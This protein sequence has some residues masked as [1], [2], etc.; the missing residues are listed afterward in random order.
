MRILRQHTEYWKIKKIRIWN[1]LGSMITNNARCTRKIKLRIP[2]AKAALTK[3]TLFTGKLDFKLRNILH[4]IKISKTNLF[5]HIWL[6]NC[7]LKHVIEGKMEERTEVTGRRERWCKKPL[8][9]FKGMR[10][11][12]KLKEEALRLLSKDRLPWKRVWD[13]S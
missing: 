13:L 6:G 2:I 12:W 3:K 7:L 4:T 5:G 1:I 10:V 9:E 8:D 11:Y